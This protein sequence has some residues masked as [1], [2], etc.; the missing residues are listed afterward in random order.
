MRCCFSRGI[1]A[2]VRMLCSRSA[3]LM[4][5]TRRSRA[6]AT[7]ILRIVAACCASLR[8]ELEPLELGDAVD[9][10]GDL[11]A[12]VGLDIGEGDLGVLDRVVQQRGGQRDLVEADVG[13]DPGHGQRVVDVA[14][15]AATRVWWRCASAAVS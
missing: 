10:G 6:I 15:A 8:V 3:S 5:S 1:A 9:D 2:I 7:S 14:L 11:G 4:T 12:E 13:D